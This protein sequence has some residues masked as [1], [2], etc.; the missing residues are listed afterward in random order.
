MTKTI[1][2]RI[3]RNRTDHK[4]TTLEVLE[5]FSSIEGRTMAN[6]LEGILAGNLC[7]RWLKYLENVTKTKLC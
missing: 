7:E 1:E 6:T 2:I 3:K 4:M 5:R